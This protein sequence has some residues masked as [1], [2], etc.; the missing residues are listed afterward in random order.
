MAYLYII[1]EWQKNQK[2]L[3]ENN[4]IVKKLYMNFLMENNQI[5][6]NKSSSQKPIGQKSWN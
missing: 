5:F 4:A 2:N 6:I 1:N 3:K